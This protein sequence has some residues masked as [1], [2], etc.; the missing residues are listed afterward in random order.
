MAAV[1][2]EFVI[3]LGTK[4]ILQNYLNWEWYGEVI[5][6]LWFMILQFIVTYVVMLQT[7]KNK[8]S[9]LC[10]RPNNYHIVFYIALDPNFA[11]V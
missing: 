5:A 1:T 11:S 10:K 8:V 4:I 2:A 3:C 9:S 6:M 7:E